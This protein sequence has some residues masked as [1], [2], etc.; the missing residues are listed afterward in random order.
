MPKSGLKRAA[1]NI[2]KAK[3]PRS[4]EDY[5]LDLENAAISAEY[6]GG[7]VSSGGGSGVS[8]GRGTGGLNALQNFKTTG[9]KTIGDV[10]NAVGTAL[11]Q[12]AENTKNVYQQGATNVG[13][14]YQQSVPVFQQTQ[15]QLQ[16][17][18]TQQAG[19][20]P[21]LAAAQLQAELNKQIQD[22][23]GQTVA[24]QQSMGEFT[25]KNLATT[26]EG[27]YGAAK[28]F[29]TTSDFDR[30]RAL[31]K[32]N[33]KLDLDIARETAEIAQSRGGGGGSRGGGGGSSRAGKEEAKRIR[34]YS[35]YI[36]EKA[37]KTKKGQEQ[38]RKA[39]TAKGEKGVLLRAK[40]QGKEK[41]ARDLLN[42]IEATEGD[43]ELLD[44]EIQ[45]YVM[46]KI[47][48]PEEKRT[49][50]VEKKR[51][52]LEQIAETF[53][54]KRHGGGKK[55]VEEEYIAR[56]TQPAIS[57]GGVPIGKQG[58]AQRNLEAYLQDLLDQY[59]GR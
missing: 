56:P 14:A 40:V 37:K 7:G 15:Q 17:G 21:N 38:F 25:S 47:Y 57:F 46:D 23:I 50:R 30:D 33:S 52:V 16:Q 35:K 13:Q 26:G 29:A 34:A 18:I 42:I 9:A 1:R 44:L 5:L 8:A 31:A 36:K 59:Y 43:K 11:Q 54:P 58:K 41:Y 28:Q 4:L 39:V 51:G 53:T 49:R 32:F 10:Y 20:T 24:R 3:S 22:Q 19:A 2:T 45:D 55:W 48:G 12:Q 27:M 6:S